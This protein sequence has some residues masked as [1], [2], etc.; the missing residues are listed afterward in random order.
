M[1]ID[2]QGAFPSSPYKY[3]LTA[4][5]VFSKYLFAVPLTTISAPSVAAAL[6]SIMFNH[7]YIP[8][9]I[10]SDLGTQFVSEL[11]SELTKLLENKITHPSLKH[12]QTIGA[13]ERSHA[14][15]TRILKL[16]S[17]DTFTNWHRYVPL[18][19][20]IHNTSY[21]TS[22]GCAPTVLFYG[23]EPMKPLDLRFYS[24]CIQKAAFNYDFVES[25]RDEMLKKFSETTESL[26]KSFARYRRY[27]DQKA[28]ANPLQQHQ[29][30][31]LLNP[32]LTEQ[33]TFSSKL[34]QKWHALYGGEKY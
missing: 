29:F 17:N 1:Q 15:L 7:S 10:I 14:A 11:F 20:F 8:K 18:V 27:Y 19:T 23:R 34:I 28:R 25:L 24:T 21:H 26:V 2:I 3:V 9:E 4:I 13:L 5:D 30:C 12:P 32:K 31:L 16:N 22:I 6:A 33:S